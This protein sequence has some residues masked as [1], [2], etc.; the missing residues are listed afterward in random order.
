MGLLL[1]QGTEAIHRVD[2]IWWIEQL[3]LRIEL[4]WSTIPGPSM[5]SIQM[6]SLRSIDQ[7]HRKIHSILT[8]LDTD[9]LPPM[10]SMDFVKIL[11]WNCRG[12]G[13]NT[14]RRHMRDLLRTQN[15]RILILM[16]TKV[17]YS[18][19]WNFFNNLGFTASTI[20][21]PIG[22]AGGIWVIWDTAQVTIRVSTASN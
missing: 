21:D 19:I 13:N 12:V 9:P 16:E 14:F 4:G 11:I 2:T 6:A 18:S 7:D 5:H 17:T 20:V 15:P 10:P 8:R 22:K 3:R 1:D